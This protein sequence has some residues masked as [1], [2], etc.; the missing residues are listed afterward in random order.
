M[1][2]FEHLMLTGACMTIAFTSISITNASTT[3]PASEK[4][5]PCLARSGENC[6]G[7]EVCGT[8]ACVPIGGGGSSQ[9]V[10]VGRRC[11][12]DPDSNCL[13]KK[14][15]QV[16]YFDKSCATVPTPYNWWVRACNED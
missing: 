6:T 14:C 3:I 8:L 12:T 5:G 9:F 15:T 1:K 10:P 4:G 7:A 11:R 16:Y 2:L 13:D